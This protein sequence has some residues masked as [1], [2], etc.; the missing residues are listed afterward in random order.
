ML[1]PMSN[2]DVFQIVLSVIATLLYIVLGLGF[3]LWLWRTGMDRFRQW[4]GEQLGYPIRVVP[5]YRFISWQIA[6]EAPANLKFRLLLVSNAFFL[7]AGL[8]PIFLL[9]M[10]G[11]LLVSLGGN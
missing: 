1:Q 5:C 3:E 11:L 8:W 9:G 2:P 7:L 10:V 4:L 6:P